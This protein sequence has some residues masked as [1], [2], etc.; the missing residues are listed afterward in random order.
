MHYTTT[1]AIADIVSVL[2]KTSHFTDGTS[3]QMERLR[4]FVDGQQPL[5]EGQA[6]RP[7]TDDERDQL[8]ISIKGFTR[9]KLAQLGVPWPPPHG[10]RKKLLRPTAQPS[11]AQS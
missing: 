11:P 4:K 9:E 6:A 8:R 7:L 5:K 2:R 10:W 1:H 3:E